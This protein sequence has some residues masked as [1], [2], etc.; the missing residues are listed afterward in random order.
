MVVVAI[1]CN[2]PGWPV[3]EPVPEQEAREEMN[4]KSTREMSVL[5][6]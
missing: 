6:N 4:N 5:R 1:T 3:V 2:C